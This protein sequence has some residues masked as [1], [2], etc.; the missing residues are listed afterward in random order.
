MKTDN[1]LKDESSE[2]I[3]IVKDYGLSVGRITKV[4]LSSNGLF[5]VLA[6][7]AAAKE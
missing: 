5:D 7:A 6:A 4:D 1:Q 3:E 2:N